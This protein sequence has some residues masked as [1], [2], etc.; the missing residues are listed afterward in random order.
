M[1]DTLCNTFHW[2]TH[3]LKGG[4]KYC[5]SYIYFQTLKVNT[6]QPNITLSLQSLNGKIEDSIQLLKCTVMIVEG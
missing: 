3:S 2:S 6:S 5:M 1:H 4:L